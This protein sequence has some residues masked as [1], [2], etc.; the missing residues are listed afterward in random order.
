MKVSFVSSQA[1][2]QAMRYQMQRMQSELVQAN[3]EV[4]SLRV[5]D[6]G[7]ALGARSGVSVSLHREMERLS[8]LTDSNKLAAS[9]LEATQLALS[10]LTKGAQGLLADFVTASTGSTEPRL[11]QSQAQSVLSMMTSVLNANL[12]GEHLFAGINTDVTPIAD[13]ADPASPNR[14]ALEDAFATYPFVDPAN[15][16]QAEMDA[17]IASVEN[18]FLGADW[19][20][21]W[22]T[23]TDQQITSRITLTETAQTSVSAN[24]PG[25]RKLAMA[26]ALVAVV[27]DADLSKEARDA[28]MQSAMK[29]LGQAIGDLVSQQSITGIVE[30]RIERANERMSM[31]ID[32]FDKTL[33]NLEGVDPYE[34]STRVSG[35]MAQI[36]LSYSLTSR[37]QQMSL[38]KFLS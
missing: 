18:Q 20:T 19:N 27:Y 35:L 4:V 1:I 14:V 17:F 28:T 26:A 24:I 22:S 9:R 6:V 38:L 10:D 15:V 11:A 37:L 34:A 36:E 2:S 29:L 33:N 8:G 7:L 13:F 23:A 21:L 25:V 31:Q 32:L 5:A 12:N 16:T 30:Q 3:K